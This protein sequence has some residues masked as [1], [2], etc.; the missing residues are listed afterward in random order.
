VAD[1]TIVG[2]TAVG[3]CPCLHAIDAATG[4]IAWQSDL[5]GPTY[6][7]AAEG[8]GVVFLGGTDA[9]LRGYALDD[10]EVLWEE[11]LRTPISGGAVVLDDSLVAVAGIRE[12]GL[13]TRSE[14]S[15]VYRF[16]LDAEE[17]SSTTTTVEAAESLTLEPTEQPC[18]GAP[19][20]MEFVLKEPPAGLAPEVTLEIDT[21]PFSATIAATDLGEP[22]DWL[23]PG[24]PAEADG[25]TEFGLFISDRDDN[26]TGGGLICILSADDAPDGSDLGCEGTS[27]PRLA[28]TYNR[29]SVVA[30]QDADTEPTLVDGFD[31]LVTTISFDPPLTVADDGS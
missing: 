23:R 9:V 18:V 16:T 14:N 4:E 17:V 28:A 31:R 8:N 2:G 12:P 24:G 25:A 6:A 5:P 29:I 27:I 10:G 26:P 30:V 19:C 15:G 22:E 13:E 7:A 3:E 11:E 20:E 21:D 1:G